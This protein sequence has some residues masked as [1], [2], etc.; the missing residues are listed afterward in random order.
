[1]RIKPG[2][3]SKTYKRDHDSRSV[4]SDSIQDPHRHHTYE[5]VRDRTHEYLYADGIDGALR[6]APS[7]DDYIFEQLALGADKT[8]PDVYIDLRKYSKPSRHQ[9]KRGTCAAFAAATI[10]EIQEHMIS[11]SANLPML[12]PEFIYHHR[13]NKPAEGMFGRD[14][15]TIMRDIGTVPEQMYPY[16]DISE[17]SRYPSHQ[18]Y[19]DAADHKIS[20]F[21]RVMTSKGLMRAI[22]EVG[23][24]Y[25]VLPLYDTRPHFW[26]KRARDS[27][28]PS[29]D[30]CG[31]SVAVVGF[32]D[33]GFILKNSW[34]P[35]W[36]GDGC[37]LFPY[38]DWD[39]HWECWAPLNRGIVPMD[40]NI[41][42]G[43]SL[44]VSLDIDADQH[45]TKK[46]KCVIS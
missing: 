43:T 2:T 26:R 29:S 22:G 31:H 15:L 28:K 7:P 13:K 36:N 30:P 34:G 41:S 39:S 45:G 33:I 27:S 24:C 11:A 35:T 32:N 40:A 16:D 4:G 5:Q 21:A 38:D 17:P 9:H 37:I 23:P 18:H 14:V 10:R 8:I 1:M 20:N 12:S 46:S 42:L 25:L 3:R 6:S 19:E 44:N